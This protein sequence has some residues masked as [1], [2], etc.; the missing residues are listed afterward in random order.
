MATSA[1]LSKIIE[2]QT[3]L[4]PKLSKL[5]RYLEKNYQDV[6]FLG[7]RTLAEKAG[8]SEASV[9]RLAY[10]CG[11]SGYGQFQAAIKDE[12]Q[13][14]LSL[15]KHLPSEEKT[16]LSEVLSMEREIMDDMEHQLDQVDFIDAVEMM[17]Q[18]PRVLVV[19]TH[20]NA[21]MAEYMAYF[22]SPVKK[23]VILI[24]ELNNQ[25][26]N[27][28]RSLPT[29]TVTVAFSFPRYPRQAL[30]ITEALKNAGCHIIGLSDSTFSPLAKMSDIH[31]SVALKYLSYVD[32]CAAVMALVNA[33]ITGLLVR[34]ND[35]YKENISQYNEFLTSK[36]LFLDKEI[37]IMS[38]NTPLAD[39]RGKQKK[40]KRISGGNVIYAADA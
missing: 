8:V 12:F 28:W 22:M 13:K 14:K 38:L 34:D 9:T 15:R 20:A 36:D 24:R 37:D 3:D 26:F 19:G 7:A 39:I 4:S 17:Y 30:I 2:N 27:C 1:V 21:M 5:A 31:F 33:L 25:S 18:A 40:R 23:D 35:N 16:L 29:G 10:A 32:P 6:A 11:F